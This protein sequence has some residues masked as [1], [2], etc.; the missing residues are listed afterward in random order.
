MVDSAF[1]N[2]PKFSQFLDIFGIAHPSVSSDLNTEFDLGILRENRTLSG[3]VGNVE[4]VDTYSFSIDAATSYFTL[5]LDGM[6]AD[7]DL[8]LYQDANRN[9]RIEGDELIGFSKAEGNDPEKIDILLNSGTYLL[10]VGQFE[11]ETNYNLNLSATPLGDFPIEGQ[12]S[13]AGVS[14]TT[15]NPVS[16]T[17]RFDVSGATF[18]TAP[19]NFL[20]F[21]NGELLPESAIQISANAISIS[22]L[23]TE[24]RNDIDIYVKDNQSLR[25]LTDTTLWAGSQT[26]NVTLLDEN[27]QPVSATVVNAKLNDDQSVLAEATSSSDGRVSF[28]NLPDRTILLDALASGNR[29]ASS[30]TI[31]SAGEV[32]LTLKGFDSPS[33]ISNNDLSQGT[34]GWNIG[35]APVSL[36]QNGE[37]VN[38]AQPRALVSTIAADIQTANQNVSNF[39]T[40]R[41][42][43][44]ATPA[45]LTPTMARLARSKAV[46]DTDSD[47]DS[48]TGIDLVLGTSGEGEQSISR[49]FTTKPGTENVTLRY[50]FITSEVPGGFFGTQYNDYF[51]VSLRSLQGGGLEFESNSMNGLGLGSFDASGATDFR[52]VTLPVNPEGDTVQ[53]DIAV[54][55]VA[56]GLYDSQVVVDEVSE[57]DQTDYKDVEIRFMSFIPSEIVSVTN[58]GFNAAIAAALGLATKNPR[59]GLSSYLLAEKIAPIFNGDNRSFLYEA[60]LDNYKSYQ[61]VVVT[62]DPEVPSGQ[63]T[64][65]DRDWGK[66]KGYYSFQGSQV[67]GKPFWWWQLNPGEQD[68]TWGVDELPVLDSNNSVLV[69]RLEGSDT[70]TTRLKVAGGIALLQ[71]FPLSYFTGLANLIPGVDI[72]PPT[73]PFSNFSL[74]PLIDANIEVTVQQEK[75]KKPEYKIEGEHDGFPAYEIYINGELAH[76][77]DPQGKF[78]GPYNLFGSGDVSVNVPWTKINKFIN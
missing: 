26:L 43:I 35:N 34:E 24:G 42:D 56:D 65:P 22:S 2:D 39:S 29:F 40:N 74:A 15:F 6:S 48:D 71:G 14:E 36:L 76:H 20:V 50:R 67:P 70:V 11:G 73:N 10:A 21:K 72:D 4:P 12:V 53:V 1:L 54:A 75:G 62:A 9:G 17:V 27:G 18:T 58:K 49:T 13:L 32:V 16:S 30:G 66:S 23:L 44:E 7:A 37:P 61:N 28:Q 5:N 57:E 45:E 46:T 64:Q 47:T 51:N 55:N 38:T 60:P 52:E 8:E 3:F 68:K 19:V 25:L 78:W 69:G 31:G 59:L 77:Y 41:R 33:P 63:V